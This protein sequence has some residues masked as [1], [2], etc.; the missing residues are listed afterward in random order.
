MDGALVLPD[1][2]G[3]TDSFAEQRYGENEVFE[4]SAFKV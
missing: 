2:D 1:M 4:I 3:C